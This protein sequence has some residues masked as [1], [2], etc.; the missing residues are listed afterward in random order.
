MAVL[1]VCGVLDGNLLGD[2]F[3]LLYCWQLQGACYWDFLCGR[4]FA[5]PL[6]KNYL[7][8]CWDISDPLLHPKET[9]WARTEIFDT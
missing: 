4:D 9:D 8:A 1:F 5:D 2:S 7:V 3:G 6:L